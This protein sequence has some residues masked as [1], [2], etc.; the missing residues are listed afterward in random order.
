MAQ[1]AYHLLHAGAWLASLT[2]LGLARASGALLGRL[3]SRLDQR[4]WDIV[5]ANLRQSFPDKDEDWVR[6]TALDCYAH[7]GQVLAEL[8]RVIR[9]SPR[10]ILEQT[11]HHGLDH[12]EAARARGKGVL[13]L[14][15]HIGNWEWASVASGVIVGGACLV[16]RPLDWEPAERLVNQWRTKSGND[17][18]PKARSARQ[19]LRALKQNRLAAA[20]LDQNV[21]WYDGEWVDFFGRLA[22]T[23]KGLALLALATKAPVL[24]YYNFRAPDGLF[25]VY[26]GPEVPLIDSG[27]KLQDVWDNTQRYTKTLEEIIRQRPEQ[28]F[29]M[30]QRWKTK[31]FHLWPRQG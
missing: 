20:L 11:R 25:D 21:D 23:N 28:W 2:P 4:H 30:H 16:A 12:L 8:P 29:W 10:A 17:V 7:L 19:I 5:T 13:L 26:F 3:G 24:P 31:P 15:G 6:Q 18:V 22:C 27:D 1:P 14:T 9:L